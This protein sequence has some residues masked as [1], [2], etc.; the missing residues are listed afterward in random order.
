MADYDAIIAESLDE[1]T[2]TQAWIAAGN[3]HFL[4]H[5]FDEAL[6]AY[7]TVPVFYPDH[8][9]LMPKALWGAAQSYAKLKDFDNQEKTMRKLI[10]DYP[11]APEASLAQ[12]EFKKKEENQP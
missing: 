1:K 8:N 12:T 4:Q 10:A 2:L 11:D 9:P 3:L 5:E 6:L 7:L